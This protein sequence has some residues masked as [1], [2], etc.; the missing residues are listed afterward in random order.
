MARDLTGA[1]DRAF[2][3]AVMLTRDLTTVRDHLDL[4]N[5]QALDDRLDALLRNIASADLSR[6]RGLA[7]ELDAMIVR[8]V[9]RVLV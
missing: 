1:L 9:D 7:A 3:Q 6:A 8:E 5:H 4:E 2:G